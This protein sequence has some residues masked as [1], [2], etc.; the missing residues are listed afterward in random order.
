MCVLNERQKMSQNSKKKNYI[1]VFDCE[2]VPDVALIRRLY[3][4]KGDDESVSKMALAAQKDESGNEFLPLPFHRIISICAVIC[5]EFGAFIKVN[6]I[7]G[8]S[9]REMIGNF[10]AFINKYEPR[11]VSFN[12][13]GFDMPVLVLRALKYNIRANAYLDTISD[14]WNNYKTRYNDQRHC[15][16]FESLGAWRGVRLDT[17]CAMAG[18][19][20]KYDTHGDEVMSLFY[21][22]KLDKI[23]EYCESDTLNT[24]MLFLKYELIKGNLSE[25]DYLSYL[26][27][28]SEYIK[29]HKSER[30]YVQIFSNACES[31]S[32]KIINGIYDENLGFGV[33]SKGAKN[34]NSNLG[35]N[36]AQDDK[37][38][39][40]LN[41][42]SN[43]IAQNSA[44][45]TLAI[46]DEPDENAPSFDEL[47]Q[48]GALSLGAKNTKT[49]TTKK[50]KDKE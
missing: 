16:L 39:V 4:F 42:N 8:D 47:V 48:S 45:N 9:E 33:K 14:K 46:N 28:M 3:G 19:P 40:N 15:D 37:N 30:G 49:K 7:D 22:N 25:E 1:C 29:T 43:E 36:S 12:G 23:H 35:E 2:S 27:L 50:K 21:A 34:E 5:D 11:L 17:V 26:S 41:Q 13:K 6:K 24:Y 31:E 18:L 32:E 44:Q 20:G 10:F 38:E